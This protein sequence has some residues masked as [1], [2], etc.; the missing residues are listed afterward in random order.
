MR[1]GDLVVTRVVHSPVLGWVL[2]C[3]VVAAFVVTAVLLSRELRSARADLL[4]SEA[5][6]G[7]ARQSLAATTT[8]F[9]ALQEA[10][11]QTSRN[12]INERG[13]RNQL[14]TD[15]NVLLQDKANLT[16]AIDSARAEG[17]D[18]SGRLA[19]ATAAQAGLHIALT[20]ANAAIASLSLAKQEAES[21]LDDLTLAHTT[22]TAEHHGLRV[23]HEALQGQYTVLSAEYDQWNREF[24][25]IVDL[26]D[27]A[28]GLRTDIL[29]MEERRRALIL[30]RGSEFVTGFTCTGSMEPKLTCLDTA[31]WVRDVA[32]AD[33]IVGATIDVYHPDCGGDWPDGVLWVAHRVIDI[34]GQDDDQ[35]Y[36]LKGDNNEHPDGCWVPHAAVRGYIIALHKNTRPANAVLRN[37]VNASWEAYKAARHTYAKLRAA[38]DCPVTG[39][40]Y[41]PDH[42]PLWGAWHALQRAWALYDCWRTNALDSE[43]PGHIPHECP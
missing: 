12:L 2:L 27:R 15:K 24:G 20:A 21:E 38:E 16:M 32:P 34:K 29:Q 37:N 42:S 40:C 26:Q 1:E 19:A 22:L 43:Y 17:A 3:A 25:A 7:V 39:T 31:T 23:A 13:T 18:V 33:I 41:V 10:Y 28:N 14:Q 11:V 8:A 6:L 30:S 5:S 36:W 35:R 9:Q 4:E